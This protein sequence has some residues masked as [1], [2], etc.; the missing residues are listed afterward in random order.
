MV[1]CVGVCGRRLFDG[2]RRCPRVHKER[3]P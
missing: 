1:E 2:E 3:L